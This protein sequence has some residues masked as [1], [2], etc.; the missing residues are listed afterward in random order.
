LLGKLYD[1]EHLHGALIISTTTIYPLGSRQQ[2]NSFVVPERRR[3]YTGTSS[4]FTN[5][6]FFHT[7]ALDLKFTLNDTVQSLLRQVPNA[8]NREK[9]KPMRN[10]IKECAPWLNWKVAAV[11]V[12]VVAC[13]GFIVGA[14]AGRLAF[15]GATPLL[16]IALC[17]MPC[18]IPLAFIRGKGKMQTRTAQSAAGCSCGSDACSVGAGQDTC[19]SNVISLTKKQV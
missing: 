11:F 8:V 18:L 6:Q 5:D 13:V 17:L 9:G 16:A 7:F 12:A 1:S 14:D 15:L 10:L 4:N 19:Q 2:A 3:P